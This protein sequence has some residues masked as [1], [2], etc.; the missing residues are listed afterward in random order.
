MSHRGAQGNG[1]VTLRCD[2]CPTGRRGRGACGSPD[3]PGTDQAAPG[4]GPVR[5]GAP[6]PGCDVAGGAAGA[7]ARGWGQWRSVG[8]SGAGGRTRP[9][10]P[11]R[12][13][14][15]PRARGH[16]AGP[17]SLTPK[18]VC[19]PR[20]P[21]TGLRPSRV[22]HVQWRNWLAAPAHARRHRFRRL[23]GSLPGACIHPIDKVLAYTAAGCVPVTSRAASGSSLPWPAQSELL[24]RDGVYARWRA[25]FTGE[26]EYA[27]QA[28]R[29]LAALSAP[30]GGLVA[31]RV[32]L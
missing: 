25:A 8:G 1:N 30:Y 22:S 31:V 18:A 17:G 10:E 15:G 24:E 4:R 7:G 26:T 23:A 13:S 5:P 12:G 28:L 20:R 16:A 32:R 14:A 27:A 3:A 11:A 29:R 2:S 21:L 19:L 6:G 9:L